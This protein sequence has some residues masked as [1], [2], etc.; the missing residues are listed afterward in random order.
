VAS[1]TRQA[2]RLAVGISEAALRK[3][4]PLDDGPAPDLLPI[5]TALRAE[6][7]AIINPLDLVWELIRPEYFKKTDFSCPPG[8][9][10]WFGPDSAAWYVHSHT[11]TVLLGLVNT[12]IIDIIHQDIQYGVYDH[13][14]LV[15]RHPDGSVRSGT[16]S[17]AGLI[18]RAGHSY[19]FFAGVVYGSSATAEELCRTVKAMHTRSKGFGPT[20]SPTTPKTRSSS[21]GPTPPLLTALPVHMSDIIRSRSRESTSTIS[22]G[23][24]RRSVRRLAAPI[25]PP[26]RPNANGC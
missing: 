14:K 12:A 26:P 20:A 21:A 8:D 2:T 18:V 25:C 17:G 23:S 4:V 16:F 6:P 24:T 22:I 7:L 13:S 3:A 9:P 1:V 5:W 10:G 15:G 19:S 11:P